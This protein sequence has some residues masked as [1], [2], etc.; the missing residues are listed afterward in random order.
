M[1][2][3][4]PFLW[5][6]AQAEEAAAFYVAVFQACGQDASRGEGGRGSVTFTLA[7]QDF[8]AF[9]GGPHFSFTPAMS[10]FVRCGDQAEV[11]RFWDGLSAGGE[12]GR[13]G[14][15]KDRFG[16]SWQVVPDVLKELLGGEDRARA[17]RVM[18][19]MMGMT[20]LDI[21]ELRAA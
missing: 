3:V 14:W 13:C 9:N 21:A 17:G 12:P 5:F 18:Q 19:A 4:T 15:L 11:D 7:G 2:K 20:K 10:L 6:D 16:V 8:I 1:P